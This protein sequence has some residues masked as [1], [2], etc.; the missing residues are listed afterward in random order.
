MI[1]HI[2]T[3]ILLGKVLIGEKQLSGQ[4]HAKQINSETALKNF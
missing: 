2:L 1:S 3:G 4:S